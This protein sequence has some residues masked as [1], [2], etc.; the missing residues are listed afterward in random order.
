[1]LWTVIGFSALLI[2]L[3]LARRK[4]S[5][6]SGKARP[7]PARR[8]RSSAERVIG[9]QLI[10]KDCV[11]KTRTEMEALFAEE[12]SALPGLSK[13]GREAQKKADQFIDVPDTNLL[14]YR[15]AAEVARC[16]SSDIQ[17]KIDDLFFEP[18]SGVDMYYKLIDK[19]DE[20][21]D[22]LTSAVEAI[23]QNRKDREAGDFP[24]GKRKTKKA[25][26]KKK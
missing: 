5:D 15:Q 7:A 23:L 14:E 2:V 21:E 25:A 24:I 4:P 13:L 17:R 19:L 20:A 16:L 12:Q 10:G 6:S 22:D 18:E 3:L 1:M 26:P 11:P 9:Y 8:S